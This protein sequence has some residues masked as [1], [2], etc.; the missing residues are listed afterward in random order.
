[1]SGAHTHTNTTKKYKKSHPK[2]K[3]IKKNVENK[4]KQKLIVQW[5]DRVTKTKK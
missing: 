4:K 2:N 3:K 5:R 1:M